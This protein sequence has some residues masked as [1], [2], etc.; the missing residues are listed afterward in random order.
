VTVWHDDLGSPVELNGP[1]RRVVSLVPSLTEAV[2]RSAPGLLVGAT[3]WCTHPSD[4]AVT[5]VRGTKNPERAAIIAL[6]P[7]LVVAN[8]E[9]NRK[10]DVVRLRDAGL[11]VWVTVI[12]SVP[13]ALASLRR[14]LTGPL[15]LAAPAWLAAAEQTWAEP[16]PRPSLAPSS[17]AQPSRRVAVPIWRDPWMVVGARTFT[18][19]V[20]ARLG[21]DNVFGA[22]PD[23]Y[24]H[25]EAEQIRA[26]APDLVLLPDEPYR[27]TP[28]DGPEEF[29]GC[30]V[31]LVPGRLLTWYGPSLAT[32]RAELLSLTR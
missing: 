32:A 9:E 30:R 11:A 29:P 10:L 14:L 17:L 12:E 2:A 15:G 5:R 16:A 23:R 18:G 22:G 6:A 13:E 21:L 25:V 8:R 28:D 19:D 7:D 24:P 4:L 27:F 20:L 26:A 31:V 1:A 3:D